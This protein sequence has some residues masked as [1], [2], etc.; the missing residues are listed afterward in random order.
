MIPPVVGHPISTGRSHGERLRVST[1]KAWEGEKIRE[2]YQ[3]DD[4]VGATM[5]FAAST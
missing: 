3:S 4:F 2:M 1:W 5:T